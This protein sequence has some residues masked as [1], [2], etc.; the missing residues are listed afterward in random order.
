ML[1]YVI[2][3]AGSDSWGISAMIDPRMMQRGRICGM[4]ELWD[5]HSYTRLFISF[6]I[7]PLMMKGEWSYILKL[8]LR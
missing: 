2:A 4:R 5:S 3:V 8:I 7:I 6:G 1:C